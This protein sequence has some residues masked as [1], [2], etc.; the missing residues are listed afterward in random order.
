MDEVD[1]AHDPTGKLE[2]TW[3]NKGDRLLSH[4]EATYEWVGPTDWRVSEVRLLHPV[5]TVGDPAAGNLLITGDALHILTALTSLPELRDEYLGKVRCVYIDPPFNTQQ[6]FATYD[7]AVE[8]SVW[9]TMLRDR[10]TQIKALLAPDGSVWVHVDD[11]EQHR[12]RC[13]MDEVFGA[14]RFV[15]TVVWQKRYS[16]DNRPAIGAVH[17]Y[18]H[19]YS[20][21]G[22]KWKDHRNRVVRQGA[23]QYRNPN[24]DK[25]GRW[26]P[27]PLDVQAGHA[28]KSQFYPV[29][30]PAGVIHKPAAGRAWSL[31]KP[32]M[33]ELI[34]QGHVYFGK[35]GRGKPNLIRY[36]D[37]DEG[38]V[39]W[40]WWPHEEV[41]HN[42]EAK[43]E[44]L[45]LFPDVEAFDTPKPERLL[46]RIIG[47]ATNEGDIAL[48]CYAGSGTT[49]AVATKMG[50]RWVTSEVNVNTV[51]T[52]TRPRL[53]A[54]VKGADPGGVTTA[55]EWE[56]GSGFTEAAVGASMF[57]QIDGV[58]ILADWATG[59][60]L[61]E[62]VCA[63]VGYRLEPDVPF[64][65]RKGR[66]RLAV[67]DGM[68]TVDV[69]DFLL[70]QLE[71]AE[72]LLIVAQSL[73]PGVEDYVREQR[74]GSRARKVPRD[75][76]HASVLTSRLVHLNPQSKAPKAPEQERE[77]P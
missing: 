14:D 49:A 13:V 38:L 67:L 42:D 68:L 10:L 32:R 27:I 34:A 16:R 60:A 52:Y 2:L 8:H 46:A 20:P 22:G 61:A 64:I 54:V 66:T 44:I 51:A 7:D 65:G 26:R 19:V 9:L 25:R 11:Y 57:E 5:S 45:E 56:G 62:A 28:T 3:A 4:G 39:P 12:A 23:K 77:Q 73:E 71:P 31:T 70:A 59:G 55:A 72:R 41:G 36:L 40:T 6:T 75:L 29:T 50:R 37:E 30:T 17:D 74:P 69:A 47:I 21:M 48:D 76:A 15:A 35:D 53:E 43:K 63:Q 58:V 1:G 18:I 24:N 33:D